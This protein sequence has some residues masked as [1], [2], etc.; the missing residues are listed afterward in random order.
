MFLHSYM[1][2]EQ[3]EEAVRDYEK[4][5]QTE[6]TK[7]KPVNPLCGHLLTSFWHKASELKQFKKSFS[8]K[9]HFIF[10]KMSFIFWWRARSGVWLFCDSQCALERIVFLVTIYSWTCPIDFV[11]L[12]DFKLIDLAN[13]TWSCDSLPLHFGDKAW[14][15]LS[16]TKLCFLKLLKLL[17]LFS[18]WS[19][20][21]KP[22]K[23]L[24]E[25][26]DFGE[27]N[28]WWIQWLYS[29]VFES[30]TIWKDCPTFFCLCLILFISSLANVC[31]KLFGKKNPLPDNAEE[32]TT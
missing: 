6:K 25:R 16:F 32:S 2:T 5:Y 14:P 24:I 22:S 21:M 30:S 9:A 8:S 19:L 1:D 31:T 27:H 13:C 15:I 11:Q 17:D 7:G 12:Y 4:I 29:F 26:E 28:G 18:G 10:D 23:P 3:Y 20:D